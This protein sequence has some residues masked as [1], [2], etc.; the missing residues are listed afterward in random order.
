MHI[1]PVMVIYDIPYEYHVS[2]LSA[3]PVT[4]DMLQLFQFVVHNITMLS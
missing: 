1:G 4:P 3:R 2:I